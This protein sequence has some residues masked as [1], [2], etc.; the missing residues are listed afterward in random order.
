MPEI[1]IPA[2]HLEHFAQAQ[3]TLDQARSAADQTA[4][5][6]LAETMRLNGWVEL[7]VDVEELSRVETVTHADGT[8]T[9]L[10]IDDSEDLDWIA[11]NCPRTL[12]RYERGDY[13]VT[14]DQAAAY[15]AG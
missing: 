10:D 12:Y 2:T 3:E 9:T 6:A 5:A 7:S 13:R 8:C 14:A 4:V 15:L 1:Q 11:G